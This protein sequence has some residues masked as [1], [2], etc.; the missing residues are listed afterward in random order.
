VV[1]AERF[2]DDV[3]HARTTLHE[4]TI[5]MSQASDNLAA[6]RQLHGKPPLLLPNA[7]DF[8]S[9]AALAADGF[10]AIATTSLGV[11]AAAGLPDGAG[12][13]RQATLAL[14]RIITRL[15]CLVS[16]DAEGGFSDEPEEVADFAAQLAALG[17]VGI[18]LEDG[19]ADGSLVSAELHTRVVETVKRRVPDLFV[20]ARTDTYWLAGS[21]PPSLS[22]TLARVRAYAAAGADGV[23]VPGVT[24]DSAIAAIAAAVD[25]PLNVLYLPGRSLGQLAELG[26]RRV[27]CGSL[28]YRIALGAGLRAVAAIRAG[29]S[30][31]TSA[32]PSYAAVEA[33]LPRP[34]S[35]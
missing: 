22:E 8:A 24:D 19:R 27:S 1:I 26:V 34:A 12:A 35:H 31:D 28:L 17:V 20:N 9:A 18:N 32:T 29:D 10:A 21:R 4:E 2:A 3:T 30:V 25:V 23:F 16:I 7:W 14:A 15:P 11:A 33:L 6:F 5:A 13:T